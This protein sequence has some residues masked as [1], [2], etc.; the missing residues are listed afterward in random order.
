MWAHYNIH[1][2][3]IVYYVKK[4]IRLFLFSFFIKGKNFFSPGVVSIRRLN[5]RLR[6]VYLDH[7]DVQFMH[8]GDLLFFLDIVSVCRQSNIPVYLVGSVDL[9]S[10][11]KIFDV[12]HI[13]SFNDSPYPG[14]VL[15]K[16]DSVYSLQHNCDHDILGINFWKISGEGPISKLLLH[17]F[18]AYC[19][20]YVTEFQFKAEGLISFED[21][22]LN[23][24]NAMKLNRDLDPIIL[25]NSFV[26]SSQFSHW[27]QLKAFNKCV[28]QKKQLHGYPTICV[29]SVKDQSQ[30]IGYQVDSDLR[31][32]MTIDELISFFATKHILEVVTFDT[33]IA[34]LATLFNI[35]ITLFVRSQFRGD[36]IRSRFV[37]FY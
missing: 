29:G 35:P 26:D 19:E 20:S 9:K 17:Q 5:G 18:V 2:T 13:T 8:L 32:Q 37:P 1:V 6:A 16:S 33:F 25:V 23:H 22:F 10:F 30:K 7:T 24:I 15:T 14:L 3:S 31:G 4:I 36:L 12:G 27:F 28:D 11:F 34:H 21:V